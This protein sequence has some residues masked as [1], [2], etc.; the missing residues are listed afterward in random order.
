M[1]Y[2]LILSVFLFINCKNKANNFELTANIKGLQKGTVYLKHFKDTSYVVLDSIRVIGD[3]EIKLSTHLSEPEILTLS[4]DK[5]LNY[6]G[7]EFFGS[8]GTTTINTSL[9]NFAYDAKI[10][11]GEQQN[12]L[13]RYNQNLQRFKNQNL[14]L[15]EKEIIAAKEKNARLVEEINTKKNQLY[16]RQYLYSINFAVNNGHSPVAPYIALKDLPE[17]NLKFL[18]TI[19]KALHKDIAKSKYGLCLKN[20]IKTQANLKSN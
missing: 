15:I 9:K 14:L 19:Y 13:D 5:N 6:D 8:A 3:T 7:I 11:A 18:D 1:R 10:F 17:A 16:K 12:L 4:L 20:Y 2:F